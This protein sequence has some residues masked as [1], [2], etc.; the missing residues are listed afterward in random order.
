V[1]YPLADARTQ[2]FHGRWVSAQITPQVV[3]LHTTEGDDWPS[4]GGGA[5]APHLS[6]MPQVKTKRLLWRQHFPFDRS[7]RAL[8]HPQ[9]AVETNGRGA[10]QV[11]L[12]GT[13][14][15]NSGLRNAL[16]WPDA[17]PW[18]L[19]GLALFLRWVNATYGIPL[20]APTGWPPFPASY[21]QSGARMGPAEWLA[22]RGVCGHLHVPHNSHGD[23]GNFPIQRVLAIAGAKEEDEM[24]LS[25]DDVN[26]IASAVWN[27]QFGPP[28][29]R[30]SAGKRLGDAANQADLTALEAR[31]TALIKESR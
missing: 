26:R 22:F 13:C 17:P 20:R 29:T 4:Y 31:L 7:S 18:A 2:W 19:N 16:Y 3:V 8:E 1:T 24:S 14:H 9:N 23:P 6:V 28:G 5:T 11:E 25:N 21:G 15:R 12:I 30:E 27:A 10:I